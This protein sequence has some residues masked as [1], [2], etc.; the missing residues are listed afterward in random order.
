MQLTNEFLA[1]EEAQKALTRICDHELPIKLAYRFAKIKDVCTKQGKKFYPAY[2]DLVVKYAIHNED[3][4][5]KT[6]P[7]N[8]KSFTIK[9]E[10]EEDWKKD[11]DELMA[12][13]FEVTKV[14]LFKVFDFE[15]VEIEPSIIKGLFPLFDPSDL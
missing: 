9:P 8:P 12:K 5:L 15:G 7:D 13:T 1:N 14:P 10:C 4:S 2:Y 3:G 11:M 6:E